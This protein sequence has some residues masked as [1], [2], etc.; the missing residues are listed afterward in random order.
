MKWFSLIVVVFTGGVLLMAT[1]DFPT[2]G[3]PNAPA[4]GDI[5]TYYL[6]NAL[7]ETEVPNVV[8]AVL[9]DYRGF[10]TMLETIVV[11][12]VGIAIILLLRMPT[13]LDNK[14]RSRELFRERFRSVLQRTKPSVLPVREDLIIRTASRLIFPVVQLFAIY[15]IVHGHHSPGGGFQ[16][17]VILGASFIMLAIA[18]DLK[19]SLTRLSPRIHVIQSTFGVAIYCG[20]GMLCLLFGSV[21]LDYGALAPL[22]QMTPSA[23]RSFAIFLIEVGVGFTVMAV[24]ISMYVDLASAGKLEEGL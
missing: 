2:W 21:F 18:Y 1:A 4:H 17:G 22:F 8:S 11:F 9:A 7:E 6:E 19:F 24:M 10:D 5:A 16:G 15:V 23:A 12:C 14:G 3:D 20:V 13:L